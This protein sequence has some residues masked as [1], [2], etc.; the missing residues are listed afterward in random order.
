MKIHKIT[1]QDFRAFFGPHDIEISGKNL[2]IYGENGSGKS[3]LYK[4]FEHFFEASTS[5]KDVESNIFTANTAPFVQFELSDGTNYIYQNSEILPN[6]NQV[7]F[8]RIHQQNPFFSY[9]RILAMYIFDKS[10]YPE[11]KL[12]HLLLD[13]VLQNVYDPILGKTFGEMY[14]EIGE[15]LRQRGN[16]NRYKRVFAKIS[17]FKIAFGA[18]LEKIETKTNEM[19]QTYFQHGI[20]LI[21]YYDNKG[22]FLSEKVQLDVAYFGKDTPLPYHDFLNEA[23]LSALAICMYLASLKVIPEPPDLKI[24]FLDDIFIGLDMGNRLPLLDI[25][26]S[27]FSA[28]QI[29]MTTYDRA[30]F[31][32]AK[33]YLDNWQSVEMYVGKDE[34]NMFDVPVIIQSK[35][36]LERAKE[37]FKAFD[38]PAA[39]NYLRKEC[40]S[41]IKSLFKNTKQEMYLLDN[42]GNIKNTFGALFEALNSYYEDCG[43]ELPK[44]ILYGFKI[45]RN[46]ILN[47]TS[48]DDLK[49]PIYKQELENTFSFVNELR[50]IQL[51]TKKKLFDCGDVLIFTYQTQPYNIILNENI[52]IIENNGQK[53]IPRLYENPKPYFSIEIND[54][55]IPSIPLKGLTKIIEKE[56]KTSGKTYNI[57]SEKDFFEN[58]MKNGI[59]VKDILGNF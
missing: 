38:Y 54:K 23:R 27:E 7:E 26:K 20:S 21:F 12:F 58:L 6:T 37:Y 44:Q 59:L 1:L 57:A 18:I 40:E 29:F 55:I 32:V 22:D 41:C 28:Y 47:P 16:S 36:Y 39:G 13:G 42:E 9:K 17:S 45:S 33:R 4:A 52:F 11:V 31:E 10:D 48:H 34:N 24:L 15:D 35:D 3:S 30:W 49:S 56:I 25:L 14:A 51:P 43:I 53:E 50:N 8:S 5:P 2:L 19:L 46:A